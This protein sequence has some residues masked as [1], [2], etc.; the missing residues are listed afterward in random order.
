MELRLSKSSSVAVVAFACVIA[1]TSCKEEADRLPYLG[2]VE[3]VNGDTVYHTVEDVILVDQD[4]QAFQLTK[5]GEKAFIAD[6]FFI[7]CPE[8]G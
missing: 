1:F 4:S 7:S 2:N 6:F 8:N 5:M 3:V